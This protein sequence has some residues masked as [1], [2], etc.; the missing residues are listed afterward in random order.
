MILESLLW[1]IWKNSQDNWRWCTKCQ[2]LAFAGNATPGS[3]PAGGTH[4]HT[5]SGNYR[6][7]K[8]LGGLL[9]SIEKLSVQENWRWCTKCQGLAFAGNPTPG[10]CP[11][12]GTHDHTGSGNYMLL[13]DVGALPNIGVASGQENWRWCTKCQGL[14]FAGNPTPGACP[15]GGTHGHTGSGN[16]TMLAV[17][18]I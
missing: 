5:G 13:K 15:A 10:S 4:D 9:G 3:C 8:D 18:S 7:P 11:A 12:G 6:L 14:A 1:D 16:Y 2:G 17:V